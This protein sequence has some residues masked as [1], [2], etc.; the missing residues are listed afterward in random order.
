MGILGILLTVEPS[1]KPP[2]NIQ[3]ITGNLSEAVVPGG[4]WIFRVK[5]SSPALVIVWKSGILSNIPRTEVGITSSVGVVEKN[6]CGQALGESVV[7]STTPCAPVNGFGG[8]RRKEPTGGWAKGIW[9]KVSAISPVLPMIVA[10]GEGTTT[11]RD[12]RLSMAGA[13]R[14]VAAKAMRERMSFMM[15][16]FRNYRR[17]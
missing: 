16:G 10:A 15:A 12:A 9:L 6:I 17:S 13:A 1:S 11:V 3:K 4:R 2:P 8:L 7:A 5:Q 14:A